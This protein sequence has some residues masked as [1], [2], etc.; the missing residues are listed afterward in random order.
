[1]LTMGQLEMT[2]VY[3]GASGRTKSWTTK[4]LA[5]DDPSSAAF[6]DPELSVDA[7]PILKANG[8]NWYFSLKG[9]E[10]Y[11]LAQF[12]AGHA[13]AKALPVIY[14]P[15]DG[16]PAHTEVHGKRL[17]VLPITSLPVRPGSTLSPISKLGNETHA[18]DPPHSQYYSRIQSRA[19]RA[20][21]PIKRAALVASFVRAPCR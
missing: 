3:C 15:I 12:K 19:D 8:E 17:K 20:S 18:G 11:S 13:R 5:R 9:H 7:E 21:N 4:I 14:K 6:K 16:N 10:G 2:Q 1:M